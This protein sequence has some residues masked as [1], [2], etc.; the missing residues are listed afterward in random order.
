MKK[1]ILWITETAV[2]LALVVVLQ[3]V[4]KAM[5]QF[6]TG[7]CVN[8]VLAIAVLVAGL[9][10]GLTV[11][12]IS[13][14]F[15]FLWKIAPNIVVVVPIMLGNACFVLL[16]H[17]LYG[18]QLYRRLSALAVAAFAKFAVLYLLVVQVICNWFADALLFKKVGEHMVLA[19]KMIKMLP[20]MFTWTQ[21]FTALLGGA[22][23]MLI[24]P[25]LRKAM[26]R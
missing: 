11:A 1:R 6:V 9:R 3:A 22:V 24:A 10:S 26:K 8:A 4:T 14:L 13:P 25:I 20:T 18:R 7:S 15:A 12:L 19:P 21:L 16:L 2:M 17:L 23:A 5:G